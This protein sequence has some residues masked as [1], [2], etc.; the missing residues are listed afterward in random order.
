[1]RAERLAT[2]GAPP[3]QV[4]MFFGKDFGADQ[5]KDLSRQGL[6]LGS[7]AQ[8]NKLLLKNGVLFAA[9]AG[10]IVIATEVGDLYISAGAIVVGMKTDNALAI[11]DLHDEHRKSVIFVLNGKSIGLL[12]GDQLV[13]APNQKQGFLEINPGFKIGYRSL[14]QFT[15]QNHK[16]MFLAEFPIVSLLVELIKCRNRSTNIESAFERAKRK[17][18]LTA[19]ALQMSTSGHGSYSS[20]FVGEHKR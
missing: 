11:Y 1:M 6:N 5:L 15:V 2:T 3:Q 19:A 17:I 4:A 16:Q 13:L 10:D 9:P 14:R 12:P 8:L 18:L 20:I 7:C